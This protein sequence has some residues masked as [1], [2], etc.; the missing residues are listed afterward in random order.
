MLPA[1]IAAV[2]G[3]SGMVVEDLGWLASLISGLAAPLKGIAARVALRV[4]RSKPRLCVHFSPSNSMW[5]IAQSG[6]LEMFHLT[7]SASFKHD[8]RNQALVIVDAY[9][10]G[11]TTGTTETINGCSTIVSGGSSNLSR[12]SSCGM[13]PLKLDASTRYGQGLQTRGN[14]DRKPR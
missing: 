7:L 14:M 8:D 5:C 1:I 11:T 3:S 12:I 6:S 13:P 4:E 9:L 2:V 10:K